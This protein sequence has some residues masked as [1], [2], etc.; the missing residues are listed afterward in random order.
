MPSPSTPKPEQVHQLLHDRGLGMGA[1]YPL[2]VPEA[3]IAPEQ[4]VPACRQAPDRCTFRVVEHTAMLPPAET[5]PGIYGLEARYLNRQTGETYPIAVPAAVRL[6]ID[7]AAM[8]TPAPELDWVTQLRTLAQRLP[9]GTEAVGSM[10]EEVGRINQYDPVQDYLAQAEQTLKYRLEQEPQ[11]SYAYTLVLA[12][13]LQRDAQGAIAAL[14]QAIQLDPQNPFPYAY[15]A[16]VYLYGFQP[17]KADQAVQSALALAPNR[18]EF[19]AL[20][21]IAALMRGN[22]VKT[23]RIAQQLRQMESPL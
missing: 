1:L 11:P 9:Q 12:T 6:E 19:V 10:F 14:E 17:G 2:P 3:A 16:F 4:A 23:W 15:L 13:A 22:L 21:G 20:D 8:P 7:P 18:F 5:M